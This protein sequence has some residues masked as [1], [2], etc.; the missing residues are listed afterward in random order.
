MENKHLIAERL[1]LAVLHLLLP[2]LGSNL[3]EGY[4]YCLGGASPIVKKCFVDG[5]GNFLLDGLILRIGFD[6]N[7]RQGSWGFKS[8]RV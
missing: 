7:V 3:L 2:P 8:L 1:N 4:A 5:L 6:T